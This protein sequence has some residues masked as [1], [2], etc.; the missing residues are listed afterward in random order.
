MEQEKINTTE[1]AKKTHDP[2]G[3]FDKD[4]SFVFVYKKTEKLAS[5]VYMIT[6]LFSDN[7]P[8]KWNLRRK[9]SDL[10]SFILEYKDIKDSNLSDFAYNIETKVLELVS[11][12]EISFRAGLISQMN[13]S[14][15]KQEFSYVLDVFNKTSLDTREYS[16]KNISKSFFDITDERNHISSTQNVGRQVSREA[17]T[18]HISYGHIKDKNDLSDKGVFRK[19]NRQNIIL[20]LLK[21]RKELTIKDVSIHI[22]DCSEKTI[23]RELISLITAGVLKRTGERR[24]SRYSLA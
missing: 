19:S 12:L 8:M 2:I 4:T 7:E 13:F 10:L 1:L 17:N 23:Q 18:T 6:N 22:R 5:A 16:N 9:V 24:W 21:K 3:F 14:I 15:I 20:N 11:L